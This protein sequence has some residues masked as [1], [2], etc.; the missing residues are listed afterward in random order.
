MQRALTLAIAFVLAGCQLQTEP[1]NIDTPA[2]SAAGVIAFDLVGPGEAALVVPVWLNGDGP[3]SFVLDT[4]ATL[5]CVDQ[6]LADELALPEQTGNIGF[7][8]GIG[9]SGAIRT[10]TVDSFRVGE[11]TAYDLTACALDLSQLENAGLEVSGL[12]GLN[13]LKSFRMTLDFGSNTLHL[14]EL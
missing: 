10:V 5:T 12:V 6:T 4:G 2:D 13:L 11:T 7:G 1:T 14:E 9:G 3:H 8:A